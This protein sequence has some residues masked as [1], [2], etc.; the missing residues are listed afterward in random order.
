[1]DSVLAMKLLNTLLEN[2][3]GQL[4]IYMESTVNLLIQEIN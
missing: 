2:L 3:P 1:M 4:D